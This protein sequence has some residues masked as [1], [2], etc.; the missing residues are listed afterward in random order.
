MKK[1]TFISCILLG[2]WLSGAM[3]ADKTQPV[4][5]SAKAPIEER[6]NDLVG[7]MTLEEKIQQLN[8]YTLGRNNNANN[9]GE[10]VKGIPAEIGSVIYFDADAQL[11]NAAQK[12]AMEESRLGIP[13]IF[14]YDVIHGFR[15]VYPISLAQ[16]CSWNLNL[17]EDAC[18][19]AAQEARMSGVDWTF[20]P[21]IDVARDGRWGRVAEGYG[22]DP[23]TNAVFG[24]ASVKGY[25]GEDMS[26]SKRVASCLKHYIGYGA[27]EA[28]RDYVYSEISNQTLWDTYIPPYEAGVKAGAATLM[29][30]F[31]DI[32]G[33]PGSANYYTLTDILKKQWKH[34][35]FVVS[36][37]GAVP[38]LIDQGSAAN[39]KEAA[40]QAFSAGVEMDMMGHCYDRHMAELVKEGKITMEQIDDAV[41]RVLRVKFRLG[42]FDTP[43]IKETTE[44]ER[45][46]LPQ[47]LATAEQL[48]EETIVLLKN[49]G[50]ILP[51]A[52]D[53]KQTIA[54]MG[55]MVKNN[56]ELLGSWSGHGRVENVLG[57]NEALDEEF[58]GKAN[59]VYADG[60]DFDGE[61]TSKF[62]EALETARKADIVLLCMGEK[63]GWS[64]ENTSRSIIELPAIQEQFI[65]EMK[66]TG[67]PIVLVLSNGRPLGLAKVEPLCDAIVEMW[68]PG[69]PGGKP[70]AGVL[71]G[72]VN[73]SGKLSITFPRSTGQIPLYYN[74][75]KSARPNSGKYQDIPSTPL[76]EFGYGLSYTTFSYGD[77][78]I[79]KA[80]IKRNEKFTVEIPVSNT[81]KRDGA[82]VVHWYISDPFCLITRPV[83]ELKHFDKQLIKVGETHTFRFEVEP[84]RDLSFVNSNGE[85]FLD[86]GE[87]YI[88]V[89]DKKVKV[90]ITD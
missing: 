2:G 29:S 25:Q 17:V 19:I 15:T 86:N 76:Y 74:Q 31:N 3:A 57:I 56:T 16:A 88:L 39:R 41:K 62:S 85:R 90:T 26:D 87:Y 34:D 65:A 32:S 89:K 38:Q 83:K 55:P 1:L 72:R 58:A 37:W 51:I 22:E 24:V 5:K 4:Y 7:K 71:S 48:A 64:G 77:I 70:L 80:D 69:V 53:S 21:M 14:G 27:S 43:Y 8:Q 78:K 75:R 36:D 50:N 18:A 6:V 59:L 61:D 30:S 66:K 49:E 60:C 67:K 54:V 81:G 10:E 73:P 23:Y 63:R 20:S 35:G 12:K 9:V 82:E 79:S 52:T 42:L 28:G 33:V 46:L 13:I 47:S 40:R 68:Q 11:R 84:M 44:Q 45:F